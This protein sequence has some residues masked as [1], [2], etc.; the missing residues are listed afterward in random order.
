VKTSNS[1]YGILGAGQLAMMLAEAGQNMGLK[2][3]LFEGQVENPLDVQRFFDS[4]AFTT[5]ESDFLNYELLGQLPENKFRPSLRCLKILRDKIEQKK[6]LASLGIQSAP[7]VLFGAQPSHSTIES[8]KAELGGALVFKWARGGYDGHGVFLENG[9]LAALQGFVDEGRRRGSE[10]FVERRISYLQELALV[11][12]FSTTGDFVSYP[13]VV[14]E[15]DKGICRSAYGPARLFGVAEEIE[16]KAQDWAKKFADELN[17]IGTFAL[18]FFWD[19][20]SLWVNEIAPRVHNSGHFSLGASTTSQFENH[21][22]ALLGM[23]LGSTQSAAVF[24]MRNFLGLDKQ[25]KTSLPDLTLPSSSRFVWYK[26]KESRLRRKLGHV[27]I[28]AENLDGWLSW[29]LGRKFHENRLPHGNF[30]RLS[31]TLS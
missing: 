16:L 22:R 28:W 1:T 8:L 23:P 7:W 25:L 14:T 15:Q 11:S 13:L 21:W 20:N 29:L 17:L 12:C 27:T 26:K 10:I 31:K 2:M 19:G 3:A 5:F 24:G 6:V 18:E 30:K 4:V 9:D